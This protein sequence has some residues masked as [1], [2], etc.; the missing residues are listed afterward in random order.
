MVYHCQPIELDS[1]DIFFFTLYMISTK[2][3]YAMMDRSQA[4]TSKYRKLYKMCWN[5]MLYGMPPTV[6]IFE[7]HFLRELCVQFIS[8]GVKYYANTQPNILDELLCHSLQ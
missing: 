8:Q 3:M 4:I 7:F 1:N 2:L 6:Q 5:I